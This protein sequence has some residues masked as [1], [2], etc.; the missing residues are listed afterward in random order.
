MMRR[1]VAFVVAVAGIAAGCGLS[2]DA[3][4]RDLPDDENNVIIA[5]PAPGDEAEGQ[6]RIYLVAPEDDRLLR[7][8]PRQASTEEELIETLIAGPNEDELT[9]QFTT[10]VPRDLE[11]LRVLQQGP[12]LFLD[13]GS[14]LT[15]LQGQPLTRALAQ[16]VY[17]STELDGVD[18]VQ[19]RVEGQSVSLPRGV[20]ANTS[21]ALSVFD[22]P[23]FVQSAQPAFPALPAT[24]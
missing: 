20:G 23:G 18:R 12:I 24:P 7:S 17:T 13:L 11:A 6:E 4:P 21:G 2:P 9:Q 22:Y 1:A 3:V 5:Q 16:I 10:F 14:Q 8:V 15:E 19:I